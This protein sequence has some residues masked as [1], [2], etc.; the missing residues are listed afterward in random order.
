M[1]SISGDVLARVEERRHALLLVG[2][3]EVAVGD[4][5]VEPV[6]VLLQVVLGQLLHLVRGV[7]ALEGIDR[8]A[9]DGL[10]QDHRRLADVLGGGV[11]R[12]VHL[13]VVVAAARQLHDLVVRHVL[14]HLPQPWVDPEEVV[15]DVGAVL[16]RVGLELTVGGGVHPV[17]QD[18][19]DVAGQQRVPFPAPDDLDDVPAGAAEVGLELLDDLAVA[20]D[21]AVELLQVAVDDPDQVV[22]LL[23]GRDPDR[24][25]GLGLGHLAVAEERPHALV[26][27]VGDAAVLEVAVEPCLVDRV[28]AGEAH[29]DGGELPEVRHQPRVG[30]RRQPGA[31][32]VLDLLPEPVELLLVEPSLEEGAGVDAGGGVA[33]DVDLVAAA[34][35]VLAAEEVVEPD[36]VEAGRGLV[37]GDV[38]ADLEALAVGA[39]DHDRGVPADERPDPALGLLVAGEPGL[40]LRRDAVDVVGAAQRGDAH[41]GLAGPLEQAQH[42][43]PG[44]VAAAFLQQGVEGRQPVL[45]LV[46]VDVGQLG[47]QAL[48]DHRGLRAG[49]R[50]GSA[51]C[52]FGHNL[53][54]ARDQGVAT[55]AMATA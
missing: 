51:G 8:P 38:A 44:P 1:Y 17:D 26:A 35:G 48:V 11:E 3:L 55:G 18:A 7:L 46:G 52:L 21:R 4:R 47:R 41:L 45:G 25:Q 28:D 49:S 39:G 33:L 12:G 29:R 10:G 15:A 30:V 27:G 14:D 22:E 37:G 20:G 32:A 53:I 23:A 40:A 13:A 34:R 43:V 42:D 54:V 50:A 2:P 31:L 36:L 5:E 19:V 16:G 24:A 6:P 9:L